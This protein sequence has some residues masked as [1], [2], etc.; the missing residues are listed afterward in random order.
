[1]TAGKNSS[2]AAAPGDGSL[3]GVRFWAQI[4]PA[5]VPRFEIFEYEGVNTKGHHMFKARKDGLMLAKTLERIAEDTRAGTFKPFLLDLR[6]M[7][8]RMDGE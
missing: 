7:T 3:C 8:A 5:R 1:M 4:Y 6:R 2:S